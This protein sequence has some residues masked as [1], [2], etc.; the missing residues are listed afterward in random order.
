MRVDPNKVLGMWKGSIEAAEVVGAITSP[1][2]LSLPPAVAGRHRD[3]SLPPLG[4]TGLE[5]PASHPCLPLA[6]GTT[7]HS[8]LLQTC[9]WLP[10]FL[11]L[12]KINYQ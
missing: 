4:P 6:V 10:G 9:S 1:V 3:P 11:W 12:L 8:L 7:L 5:V 2:S